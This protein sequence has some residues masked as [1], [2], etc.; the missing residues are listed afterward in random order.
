ASTGRPN[1]VRP[2][3]EQVGRWPE[4]DPRFPLMDSA[5]APG[6]DQLMS[7]FFRW[8]FPRDGLEVYGEVGRAEMPRSLKDLLVEP[9]HS[10]GYTGG[11]QYIRP[12]GAGAIRLQ[13]EFTY[14]ERSS[15]YRHR[16]TGSW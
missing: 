9:G 4:D 2:E 6:R 10:M 1:A 11:L 5:T 3:S 8:V 12:V 13:G 15:S 16:P 7:L 14:L